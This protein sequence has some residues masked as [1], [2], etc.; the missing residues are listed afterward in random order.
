MAEPSKGAAA[1]PP[2]DSGD[3]TGGAA[4]TVLNVNDDDTARYVLSRILRR[5]GFRVVE[6]ATGTDAVRLAHGLPDLIVL[7]V[8]L[9]DIDGFEV[10]RRIK[11]DPATLAIPVLH[12]SASRVGTAD[13]ALGLEGGADGYL[14]QPVEPAELTATVRALLRL[15][16]AEERARRAAGEWRAVFDAIGDGVCLV[17]PGGAVRQCNRAM[18]GLAG[19]SPEDAAGRPFD[20]LLARAFP[21]YEAPPP[22]GDHAARREVAEAPAGRRWLRVTTEPVV[23]G[24]AS[25]GTVRVVTDVTEARDAALR[26]RTFLREILAGVTEGRLLLCDGEADLPPALAGACDPVAVSG[27]NLAALRQRVQQAARGAGLPE[28]RVMDIVTAAGEAGMNAVVHAGGGEARVCAPPGGGAVQ[29]WVRDA[30]TGI[31][32]EHLHQATLVRGFSGGGGFGHGFSLMLSTC[33]RVSLLTG[34]RGTTLVLEQ[35]S[36]PPPPAWLTSSGG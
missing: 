27:P 30:G 11:A 29:V 1:G 2:D 5:D 19:V 26:H 4:P 7:D 12:V 36:E 8:N 17:G 16:R 31:R 3:G 15:S 34:A 14:A 21:G 28:K 33:D 13:K 20:E 9:P 22:G 6:A 25:A 10:C 35:G 18:A 32:E 23:H 24:D